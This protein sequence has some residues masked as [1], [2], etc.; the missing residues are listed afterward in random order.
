MIRSDLDVPVLTLET[1]TDLTSPLVGYFG[2]RQ[3]DSDR[4]RL[5]ETAGAAHLDAY[6][7][8]TG[9]TD[10]GD[11]PDIVDLVVTGASMPGTLACGMPINSGPHHFVLNAAFAALDRWVRLGKPPDP[12]PRL[13]IASGPPVA[14]V[15]DAN[16]NA[17]GGIR[18]PQ[19]D[20]PT[21]AFTGEQSG[22]FLC[23]LAGTTTPF[24]PAMLAQ[25][26]PS[27]KAFVSAYDESLRRAVRAGW[28][29]E[30][31]AKLMR[32]WAGG[33]GPGGRCD[34]QLRRLLGAHDASLVREPTAADVPSREVGT[35]QR[36]ER[37]D[38]VRTRHRF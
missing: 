1:E 4:F 36:R 25:L 31:D 33:S 8:V 34:A 28:I 14:I 27:H 2:A 16:G 26:Y 15:R 35:R 22:T 37:C 29:L 10:L 5:W 38:L 13:E 18:T 7:L 30:P 19:V 24:D 3:A 11:S 23:M 12:A 21:A 17:L 20:V 32:A 9:A 6:L